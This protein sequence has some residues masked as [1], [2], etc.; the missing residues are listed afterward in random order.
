MG[1][2]RVRGAGLVVDGIALDQ[3]RAGVAQAEHIDFGTFAAE[4]EDHLV[5]A[6]NSRNV[7]EARIRHID[8][9]AI[10]NLLEVEGSDEPVGR[11]KEN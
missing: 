3:R 6:A 7:P 8:D 9:D 2:E 5:E 10:D 4:L 11:R 1:A